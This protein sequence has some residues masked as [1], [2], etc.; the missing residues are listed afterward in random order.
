MSNVQQ[1]LLSPQSGHWRIFD[2]AQMDSG[3]GLDS[4]E[5]VPQM[6]MCRRYGKPATLISACIPDSF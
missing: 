2:L 3:L 4:L 5:K 1:R 6:A